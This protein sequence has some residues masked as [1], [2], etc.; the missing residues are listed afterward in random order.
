MDNVYLVLFHIGP[1]Q[2]FIRSARRSRDLWFGSW[3]LSEL[4]KTAALEIVEQN[5]GDVEWSLIFPAPKNLSEL[6]SDKFNVAN[7]IVARTRKDPADLGEAVRN[8]V[9][10]RLHEISDEAFSRIEAVAEI[11]RKRAEL[12]V[13]DLLEL[14]WVACPFDDTYVKTRFK[15]ESLMAARKVTRNFGPSTWACSEDKSSLDGLRESVIPRD[16]YKNME[17]DLLRRIYD[18]SKGERLCGIGILKRHGKR[19]G[20]NRFCSTSHMAA[21]PLLER[22]TES[23]KTAVDEY[24]SRL[25]ELGIESSALNTVPFAHDVFGHNDGH[26]LFSER[27]AEFFDGDD[28]KEAQKALEIV[29]KKAFGNTKPIPY[30]VL[31]HADGDHMG[32]IINEQ[33]TVERHRDL[34]RRLS[35]FAQEVHPIVT[36]YLGSPIYAGGED[37]LALLPMHTALECAKTLAL[38]FSR[39]MSDFS[40]LDPKENIVIQPTLSVGLAIVH[41]LDPLSKSLDLVR[42]AER[43]AKSIDGKNA[44][45]VSLSK[46][47]GS[48]LTIG[49][50]WGTID[51]RLEWFVRL[52]LDEEMPTEV[53]YELRS[54]AMTLEASGEGPN[55][56][57]REALSAEVKRILRRK[58]AKHGTREVDEHIIDRL[59]TLICAQELSVGQLANELIVARELSSAYAL[60]G[61]EDKQ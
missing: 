9:L 16:V 41:H 43:Y 25:K 38:T 10:E 59:T 40:I 12:Q 32:K 23:D 26:L 36:R 53:A 35:M 39:E 3:L 17:K 29:L 8:K 55:L 42:Q 50:K 33:Q 24:I 61:K 30:Y 28:L 5:G 31:L 49:G 51:Q 7:R 1:V 37:V 2:E 58:R 54:L 34:S 27:L 46:R 21:M 45:A 20:D 60:A 15:A 14:F 44:L 11:N 47:S 56:V 22:L 48:E 19:N 18:V 13:D 4:S 57:P 6:R 52:F